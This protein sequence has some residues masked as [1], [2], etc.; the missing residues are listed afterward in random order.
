[1]L[2]HPDVQITHGKAGL[3]SWFGLLYAQK[4]LH[5]AVDFHLRQECDLPFSW[6]EI[7][8]RIGDELSDEPLGFVNVS[9]ITPQVLLSPSRVSRVLDGLLQRG[10]IERRPGV[11][12]GRRAEVTLT[13][14]GRKLLVEA[15]AVHR[16]TVN[17]VM[18]DHLTQAEA[19]TLYQV[20]LKLGIDLS[21]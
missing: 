21:D 6:F 7:L 13:E 5:D 16:R 14:A 8:L 12:D 10:L 18:L 15:D 9:A 2:E 3:K 17:E 20:W 11:Q 4:L 19:E 1:M